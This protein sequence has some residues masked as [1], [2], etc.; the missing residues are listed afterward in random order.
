MNETFELLDEMVD[1]G[2]FGDEAKILKDQRDSM[3]YA[4]S[5]KAFIQPL[6]DCSNE[7]DITRRL[8]CRVVMVLHGYYQNAILSNPET[9][10]NLVS[11][12]IVD[13]KGIVVFSE[14]MMDKGLLDKKVKYNQG[15]I[16]NSIE[17]REMSNNYLSFY[18]K[19]VE[20]A[21]QNL[22]NIMNIINVYDNIGSHQDINRM[23]LNTKI[24]VLNKYDVNMQFVTSLIDRSLRNHISHNNIMFNVNSGTLESISDK[25]LSLPLVDFIFKRIPKIVA[26]NRAFIV[27]IYL[28][29]L[30]AQDKEGYLLYYNKLRDVAN[31]VI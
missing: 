2:Y 4:E 24:N 17:K 14:M 16:L 15:K 13:Q 18:N 27:S 21:N 6:I 28:V 30:A 3:S 5:A 26:L 19:C 23:T 7:E 22:S 8:V 31:G 12:Y 9:T 29:I 10:M 25:S 20:L 1:E 11:Q